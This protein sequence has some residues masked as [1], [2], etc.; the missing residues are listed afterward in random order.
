MRTYCS[1]LVICFAAIDMA[2]DVVTPVVSPVVSIPRPLTLAAELEQ[3]GEL[4]AAERILLDYIDASQSPDARE[5]LSVALNNLAI[6]Y[7]TMERAADAELYFKRAIRLLETMT[8][9]PSAP[10][11]I[12]RAK[13][14]LG[15]F[16]IE[17]RRSREAEK[18]NIKGIVDDLRDSPADQTRAR[19]MIAALAMVYNDLDRA[20][21]ILLGVVSFWQ[22]N[23]TLF[24]A[25]A[26]IATA[27]NNLGIIAWRQHRTDVALSRLN[28]S[29]AVWKEILGPGNPTLAKLMTNLA[30]AC[31]QAR[32]YQDAAAWQEQ[33]LETSRRALGDS[34]PF[35]VRLQGVYADILK[36]AGRK[37]EAGQVARAA[38]EARKTLRSRSLADYT[39]DYRDHR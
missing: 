16:Y 29:L 19:S 18:L 2:A 20:E 5:G 9:H 36:K 28:Q 1:L 8:Y 12:A 3:K 32:R 35:T 13:V 30:A 24:K 23:L 26:E 34:H 14:N 38:A 21:Q 7:T 17:G 10:H 15:S 31:T 11:A 6:L 4:Q 27:L 33:A 22:S 25:Q 39:I 37:T